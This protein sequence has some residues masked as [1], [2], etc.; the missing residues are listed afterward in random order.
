MAC[1][2][3]TTVFLKTMTLTL[4]VFLAPAFPAAKISVDNKDFDAGKIH[5]GAVKKVKH[6]FMI[7]N[8]GSD[9]LRIKEVKPG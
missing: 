4:A 6:T 3:N 5:E 8:T 1:F 7:T 9:T 2:Y